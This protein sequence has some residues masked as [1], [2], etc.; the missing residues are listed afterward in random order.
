LITQSNRNRTAILITN[1]AGNESIRLTRSPS[2]TFASGGSTLTG[3]QTF[4]MGIDF[5]TPPSFNNV[6]GQP[7]YNN[8]RRVTGGWWA[9]AETGSQ[10]INWEPEFR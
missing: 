6:T 7:I 3:G 2:D 4:N 10:T 1:N 8:Q 9:V 5:N